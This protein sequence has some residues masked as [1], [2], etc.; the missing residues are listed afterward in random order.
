[1][2]EIHIDLIPN[3]DIEVQMTLEYYLSDS[4]GDFILFNRKNAI[5]LFPQKEDDIK[6]YIKSNKVDFDITG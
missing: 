1:M 2:M 5:Q 4:S 6:A 3:E